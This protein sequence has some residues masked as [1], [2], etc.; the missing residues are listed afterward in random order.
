MNG[1]RLTRRRAL[2]C[3]AAFSAANLRSATCAAL[4]A[5]QPSR[6]LAP[7]E[8]GVS[9][10]GAME[11]VRAAHDLALAMDHSRGS[12]YIAA[13]RL[14]C[15]GALD[16]RLLS[17]RAEEPAQFEREWD[18]M[19]CATFERH[20]RGAAFAKAWALLI[21]EALGDARAATAILHGQKDTERKYRDCVGVHT[22]LGARASGVLVSPRVV[23]T[24]RHVERDEPTQVWF[25]GRA[26]QVT[27]RIAAP[28]G[29]VAA[30]WLAEPIKADGIPAPRASREETNRARCTI[31]AGYGSTSQ[32][33]K[34]YA[35]ERLIGPM[36]ILDRANP[37]TA[38]HAELGSTSSYEFI[39]GGLDGDSCRGDSGG[40]CYAEGKLIG[41]TSRAVNGS[42]GR[43][44]LGGIYTRVV[45]YAHWIDE[46]INEHR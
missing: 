27:G 44:G 45:E 32:D 2:R 1:S 11:T 23:L 20:W 3:L 29:D 35:G 41:I 15:V 18:R 13:F 40:G 42:F 34:G 8:S 14:L 39:G 24:A 7:I 38:E 4:G 25:D 21:D 9:G 12:R 19:G 43:C 36:V 22:R 46:R 6:P 26:F 33:G 5:E 31:I 28:E 30:M 37:C 16:R 17:A 10:R